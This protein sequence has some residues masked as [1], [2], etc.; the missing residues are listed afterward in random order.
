MDKLIVTIRAAD[1]EPLALL[2]VDTASRALAGGNENAPDDMG[3]LVR[4]VDRLR[5]ELHCHVVLVHHT[6]KDQS[7]GARGHSLLRAAVDTEIEVI[8]W[9]DISSATIT[10]QRDG[11]SGERISFRLRQVVLGQDEDGDP[12]T[13]CVVEPANEMPQTGRGAIA[14]PKLSPAQTRALELLTEAIGKA[15][16][17][18][19]PCDHIPANE[20]CVAESLWRDCC[21]AG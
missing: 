8:R 1:L 3:A 20:Q 12:V 14:T 10:K 16:E 2:I 13:S 11:I 15:G 18:P 9:S 7:R 17:I 6:G 5:D 4:S 21:Y 19:P